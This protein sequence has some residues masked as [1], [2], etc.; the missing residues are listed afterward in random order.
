MRHHALRSPLAQKRLVIDERRKRGQDTPPR[1][2]GE[3]DR[4]EL[5]LEQAAHKRH[6]RPPKKRRELPDIHKDD[7]IR[8]ADPRNNGARFDVLGAALEIVKDK[9]EV[10]SKNK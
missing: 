4:E 9:I 1:F 10:A 2:P 7:Q 3:A 6:P 5:Q 8:K